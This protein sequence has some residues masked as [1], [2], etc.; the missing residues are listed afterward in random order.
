MSIK[1]LVV[2]DNHG[3]MRN[4]KNAVKHFKGDIQGIIHCGDVEYSLNKIEKLAGCPVYAAK[5]NC[6]FVFKRDRE[7]LFELGGK[8]VALVTHGD[9]H[10]VS[11]T[12]DMVFSYAQEMGADVVFYGHTH[13]PG[14]FHFEHEGKVYT[15][16]NPGSIELPRQFDPA[17]PTFATL[18]VRDDG[19]L[20]PQ[21][22]LVNRG[23]GEPFTAI[24]ITDY[25]MW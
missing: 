10:G 3:H 21:Y 14:W 17:G 24:N 5:G 9:R 8:H 16:M 13:R 19:E 4:L 11:F 1:Y 18:E 23:V 6:D 22:Y 7:S 15:F 25:E 2:S 12:L 20:I